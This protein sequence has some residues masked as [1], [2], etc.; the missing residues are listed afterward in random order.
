MN[1]SP[2]DLAVFVLYLVGITA[3]GILSVRK[4]KL[5]GEMYFLAGRSL[6]WPV[7]GAEEPLRDR[8]GP[9]PGTAR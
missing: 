5:T 2:I 6:R 9:T 3:A 7:V 1:I 4:Q 8:S